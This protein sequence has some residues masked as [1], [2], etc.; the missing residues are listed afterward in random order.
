MSAEAV[1][2]LCDGLLGLVPTVVD[3]DLS[4][5]SVRSTIAE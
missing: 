4:V 1:R 3:E 5:S 2:N